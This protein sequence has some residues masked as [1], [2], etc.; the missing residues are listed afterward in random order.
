MQDRHHQTGHWTH[1]HPYAAF[2]V[3]MLYMAF[4]MVAPMGI[5]MLATMS[6]M[7]P[8][9]TANVLL[10]AGFFVLLPIAI[11]RRER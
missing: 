10:I 2:A 7:Y 9:R 8:N 4:T 11:G 5:L 6:G 1:R 3:N